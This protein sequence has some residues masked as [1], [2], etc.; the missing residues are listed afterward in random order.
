[1]DVKRA[2]P[3]PR[4]DGPLAICL[5]DLH[6][7][8]DPRG[9][10]RRS[11]APAGCPVVQGVRAGEVE[12]HAEVGG[13]L[14]ARA[15]PEPPERRRLLAAGTD[16]ALVGCLV[17]VA[18]T[19]LTTPPG[20]PA[21]LPAPGLPDGGPFLLDHHPR[22]RCRD[23]ALRPRTGTRGIRE[24]SIHGC[25]CRRRRTAVPRPRSRYE[26][27]RPASARHQAG[28]TRAELVVEHDLAGLT[29]KTTHASLVRLRSSS[30]E[31]IE[32]ATDK[33][34]QYLALLAA[35]S[36]VH[37]RDATPR[38]LRPRPRCVSS[39]RSRSRASPSARGRARPVGDANCGSLSCSARYPTATGC[40]GCTGMGVCAD[41]AG[42]RS[43]SGRFVGGCV[44]EG[45]VR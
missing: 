28:E 9:P 15:T 44:G 25:R 43:G 40:W 7:D 8:L 1:M 34:P 36:E 5:G 14:A 10:A 29:G 17:D 22:G 37:R 16:A 18:L 21:A 11:G 31:L 23:P 35:I 39:A 41:G 26:G 33:D 38:R 42:S 3:I 30:F 12:R 4:S 20:A 32:G 13:Q 24:R 6:R 45:G 19:C 27:T 2:R